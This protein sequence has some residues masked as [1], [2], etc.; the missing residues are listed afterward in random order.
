MGELEVVRQFVDFISLGWIMLMN[1]VV[2]G[3]RTGGEIGVI[4]LAISVPLLCD[5]I[6]KQD[7]SV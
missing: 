6:E 3:G 4:S 5:I 7:H 2:S 1:M